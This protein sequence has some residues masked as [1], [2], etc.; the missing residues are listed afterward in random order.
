MRKC[1]F[2]IQE[3]Q[4]PITDRPITPEGTNF[5][6]ILFHCHFQASPATFRLPTSTFFTNQY[7][8]VGQNELQIPANVPPDR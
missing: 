3:D 4:F 7:R 6:D 5:D 8:L 2:L 1:L